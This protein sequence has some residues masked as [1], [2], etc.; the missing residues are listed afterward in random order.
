V[1]T[2]PDPIITTFIVYFCETMK[3][4]QKLALRYVRAELNILSLVNTRK[5]A[6]KAFRLFCTPQKKTAGKYPAI[7]EAGE[8]LAFQLEG[9]SIR[10][11][12]WTPYSDSLTP[13]PIP[14]KKIL[15]A[16]GFESS[17]RTFDTY[18]AT[19]LKE[20]YEVVAFDAPGHGRSGGKRILLTDYVRMLQLIEQNYGPFQA[21]IGHSL[22]GLALTLAL[23]DMPVDPGAR[24]VLL[25]P[26]VQMT[27]AVDTFARVLGLTPQVV[28]EMDRY[29]QEISGHPFSWFSLRRAIGHVPAAI[30]YCQDEDD[31][32]VP[33]AEA[34]EV[35]QDGHAHV[36]FIFTQGLGH[37]NIYKAQE[38]LDQVIAFL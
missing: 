2:F 4:K 31:L 15:I 12:R 22:G 37:R 14:P 32:I 25:A 21:R 33:P 11:H 7:F 35:E 28:Q 26:A 36:R 9:R 27:A 18:I 5:A 8:R 38:M 16:H 3:L 13:D 17:S 6:I 30:L 10:G 19:L 29:V 34:R 20:G 23:E 24:L 1:A